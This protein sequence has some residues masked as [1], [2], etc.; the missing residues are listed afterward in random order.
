MKIRIVA[1]VQVIQFSFPFALHGQD[2]AQ[3]PVTDGDDYPIEKNN[4]EHP[5]ITA[6]QYQII[7][8]RCNENIVRLGLNITGRSSVATLLSWPLHASA[9]LTDCSY[10]HI[11]AYVDQD[12]TTG[13]FHDFNCGT[14][15]YDGHRGTDISTWPFNFYKMDNNLVEVIAAA[16]GIIID[17]HDGEF[18]RNCSSNS[19]TANYVIIQHA[20][21][22]CA[23]YWH[24]K[25][26]YV[27]SVSV[28]Q[29][30]S[31]GDYLGI[32]GSSGSSS[33]P[34]LHF[35][36]WNGITV[37][38]R[39]DPYFGACNTL[40]AA[41]WWASQKSYKETAVIRASA[42]TTDI[43]VPTC[44]TTETLNEGASFQ[45]PF[46]GIGLSPGY[47]KFYIFIRDEVNGLTAN[48]SIL[49]PNL[50]P[51]LSWTYSSTSDNKVR[52]WGWSKLLPTISG[53]YTFQAIYNGITCSSTFEIINPTGISAQDNLTGITI[54]PDPVVN[55]LKIY[56]AGTERIVQ[57]D[58][59]SMVGEK[60]LSHSFQG[61]NN[62]VLDVQSLSPGIYF[63]T[64]RNEKNS[65]ITRKI[66]KM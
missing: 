19:L 43:V 20:D 64:I 13:T 30:V 36:I 27:T 42:H 40:N 7:E 37:S 45:I 61:E 21:G 33:G 10:Y 6:Q 49:N 29:T 15:T 22:S 65:T 51:Y 59:F 1:L 41:S 66:V 34:H 54:Y 17:K 38:T 39:V 52:T 23:L 5:C 35:E 56:S 24:M 2:I 14:N 58:V 3:S 25:K 44:P 47:A 16:P 50:T 8:A 46:Q 18:D 26:D 60:I 11:A 53:T 62:S 63:V 55:E 32:V 57:A 28:G 4:A 48:L 31:T 12:T 9:T